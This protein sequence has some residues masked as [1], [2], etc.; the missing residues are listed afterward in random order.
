MKQYAVI[1]AAF[2]LSFPAFSQTVFI[3]ENPTRTIFPMLETEFDIR[4]IGFGTI[5]AVNPQHDYTSKSLTNPA[6]LVAGDKQWSNYFNFHQ[7][8]QYEYAL[9]FQ[10]ASKIGDKWSVGTMGRTYSNQTLTSIN[11]TTIGGFLGYKINKNW[12]VGGGVNYFHHSID[13]VMS[14]NSYFFDLGAQ[15]QTSFKLS[16]SQQLDFQAGLKINYLGPKPYPYEFLPTNLSLATALTYPTA[17]KGGMLYLTLGYQSEKLLIPSNDFMDSNL[18]G[19]LDNQEISAAEGIISSFSDAQNGASEEL[20]EI[21]HKFGF[22]T[23]YI[24]DGW[25]RG[26]RVGFFNVPTYKGGMKFFS[27]GV[28]FGKNGYLM[29][30]SYQHISNTDPDV[31]V[32]D[33]L[34][35]GLSM[36]I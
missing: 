7:F 9:S 24:K 12:S 10:A 2:L 23:T 22:E 28:S 25:I 4:N 1:L 18:N 35:L 14:T 21:T 6:L 3:T 36:N 20:M 5:S 33:V 26:V 11:A 34:S 29:N 17:L 13:S 30:F 8:D 32:R 19:V 31:E 16:P 27:Y 15:Y